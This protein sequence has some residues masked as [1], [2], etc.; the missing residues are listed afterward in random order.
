MQ[1][2]WAACYKTIHILLHQI[3]PSGNVR[4]NSNALYNYFRINW[5]RT[6]ERSAP[7]SLISYACFIFMFPKFLASVTIFQS[8]S[9]ASSTIKANECVLTLHSVTKHIS[10]MWGWSSK[11]SAKV[12]IFRLFRLIH[13][14]W[15]SDNNVSFFLPLLWKDKICHFPALYPSAANCKT[16]ALPLNYFEETVCIKFNFKIKLQEVKSQSLI[17]ANKVG[18]SS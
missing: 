9:P 11:Y 2:L 4:G 16:N 14:H 8:F 3:W 13:L 18:K 17:C 5:V 6:V 1:I 7:I 10:Q 12:F 15:A